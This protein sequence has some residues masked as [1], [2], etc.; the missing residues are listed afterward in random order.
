MSCRSYFKF[1]VISPYENLLNWKS[2]DGIWGWGRFSA[3][4]FPATA[5]FCNF[6]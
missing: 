3:E 1:I 4:G 5:F 2:A 6:A